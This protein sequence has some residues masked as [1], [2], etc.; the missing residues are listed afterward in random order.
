MKQRYI[1]VVDDLPDD[2]VVVVRGGEL[3][4]EV[5]RSD[6]IRYHSVYGTYGLSVFAARDI[7]VDELA[8]QT[9]LVRFGVLTLMLAGV[10]RTAGLRQE[11]TGRNPRHFTVAFEDLDQGV[12]RLG[13]CEHE[14]WRNQ[15]HE[16]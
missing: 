14:V 7:T 5:L 11:P 9:P 4:A 12:E 3:K 16:D 15:Y 6:A 10:I 1:R 2:E 13:R 8:Q